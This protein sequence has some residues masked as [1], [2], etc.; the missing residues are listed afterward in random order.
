LFLGEIERAL[1]RPENALEF[2]ARVFEGRVAAFGTR[3]HV[4]V[5]EAA[6]RIGDA[7]RELAR[8]GEAREAYE[9]SD[10]RYR[11]RLREDHPDRHEGLYGLGLA[12][13]ASGDRAGAK[14]AADECSEIEFRNFEAM[15]QFTDERQR[16]A[17][18]DMFKS[19]HL[20]ANLGEGE[21]VAA[22]LLR[23]KGVVT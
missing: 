12:A 6:R 23:Q 10:R 22:F 15:L 1:G 14:R 20:Y 17:Y 11:E 5:A 19:H 9:E 8:Y 21:A 7:R 2:Y 3:A 4:E 16:L 18:Q 13:L